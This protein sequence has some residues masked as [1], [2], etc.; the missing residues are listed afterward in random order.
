M[1]IGILREEKHPIDNRAPLT[2][3]QCRTLMEEHSNLWVAV[4]PSKHRCYTDDEYHNQGIL[5]REDLS[6]CDILLGV[7]EIP[8]Q[9]FIPNKTYFIF[10]HTIKKQ[11]HNKKLLQEAL[12]KKIRLIDWECLKDENSKRIIAFGRWAGIV[13]AYNGIRTTGLR[14]QGQQHFQLRP[15]YQCLNFAETQKEFSKVNLPPIKIVLTGTGRVSNGAAFLLDLLNIPKVSPQDFLNKEYPTCVY[16]QLESKHMFHKEGQ[17]EFNTSHYHAHLEQYKSSFAPYTKV[18][19]VFINGIYWDKRMPTFF[20]INDMKKPDFKIQVIADITCDIA[21]HSSVPS[22]IR[23]S[24]ITNPIYGYNPHTQTECEPF[25]PNAID[26]M[27]IDNLP[28]ELPRDASEDFGNMVLSRVI[29][30]LLKEEST[31]L[32]NATITIN[33]SLNEPY[34]YLS[35][36]AYNN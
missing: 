22:T 36:Y 8:A 25:Q 5:L 11:P 13:G 16:T 6:D 3:S 19:T 21:P 30:R 32:H 31:T 7:K 20:T 14:L 18:A 1:K 23:P 24:T 4:Q 33:G 34:Q 35:D 12:R 26:V 9:L 28:N 29:W 17:T 27:A 2:P 10:S 15:M